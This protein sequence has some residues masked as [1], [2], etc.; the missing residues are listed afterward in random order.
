VTFDT[1]G[2]A[3]S[4]E[5]GWGTIAG[6]PEWG[7]FKF[8]HTDAAQ[9][10]SGLMTLILMAHAHHRVTRRLTVADVSD[11][12]FQKWVREFE[13]CIPH[14]SHSTGALMEEMVKRGPGSYDGLFVYENLAIDYFKAAEGRWGKLRVAYPPQ[15]MWSDNPYYVLDVPW[16][17]AS[18]RH[19]AEAFLH[20]LMSEP[21]QRQA[22]AHGFRPGDVN[23]PVKGT[24]DSPFVRCADAGLK[25]ELQDVVEPPG[26]DVIENLLQ[27]WAKARAA[28]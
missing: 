18:Q 3:L 25:V 5:G 9:S 11:P 27:F 4:E 19:A 26:D 13:A 15:N 1:V 10:N 7:R 14:L 6:R 12:A 28:K 8:S 2:R 17:S 24:P 20:F 21:M 23:I 22:L 16:S